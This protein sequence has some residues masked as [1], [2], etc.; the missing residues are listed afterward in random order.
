MNEFT[1]LKMTGY[2][3]LIVQKR[4]AKLAFSWNANYHKKLS[5]DK[6]FVLKM[7]HL[8]WFCRMG[9]YLMSDISKKPIQSLKNSKITCL[10]DTRLINKIISRHILIPNHKNGALSIFHHSPTRTIDLGAVSIK[11]RWTIVS[12]MNLVNK[13]TGVNWYWYLSMFDASIQSIISRHL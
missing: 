11:F 5:F 3:R 4:I 6:E 9:H 1:S 12:G 8:Y 10:K 2:R 7:Y 13:L